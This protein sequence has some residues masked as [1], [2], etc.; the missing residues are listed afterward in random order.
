MLFVPLSASALAPTVFGTL[1]TMAPT[2]LAATPQVSI[3]FSASA[4]ASVLGSNVEYELQIDGSPQ[5]RAA[6]GLVVG[7]PQSAAIVWR[8]GLPPGIHTIRVA[9]RRT[10]AGS[11]VTI[12]PA[13]TGHANLLMMQ[14]AT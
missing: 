6:S 2:I 4:L 14:T 8:V 9:W 1:V 10:V 3:W 12:D 7:S 5:R 13:L 11:T